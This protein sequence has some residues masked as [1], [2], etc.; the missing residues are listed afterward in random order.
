MNYSRTPCQLGRHLIDIAAQDGREIGIH[1]RGVAARHQPQQRADRVAGRD[2]GETR[3]RGPARRG[4]A[5]GPGYFQACISTIATARDAA[6]RAPREAAAAPRPRPAARS[7]RRRTSTR[8]PISTTRSYSIDGSVIWRSNSRGRAWLPMRSASAKPRLTTSRVRSPLRSSSALVATVVPIF[9]A[10]S[11][12]AGSARPPA[13]RAAADAGH[14]G[15]AVAAGFSDSSLW[16]DSRPSGSR[17]TMSV[18]VPPRSIQ[19]CQRAIVVSVGP[20]CRG[21]DRRRGDGSRA[22]PSCS[23]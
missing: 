9:T 11:S 21:A 15:V 7:R 16:V 18:K 12:P 14:G 23:R 20:S 10:R 4:A 22:D 2:L 5:R 19:N 13:G 1:H 3:P 8:P 6:P 17:A